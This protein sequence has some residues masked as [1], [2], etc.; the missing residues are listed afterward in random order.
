MPLRFERHGNEVN[1]V[2]QRKTP[3]VYSL[4]GLLASLILSL[5]GCSPP[6]GAVANPP[7]GGAT[8]DPV[9][10]TVFAAASLTDAFTE[11]GGQFEAANPEID[12][13]FNFA[14]SQQ[15]AQQL[16]QGAPADVFASANQRQMAV[17]ITSGRIAP[18]APQTFAQN[19][20]VVIFPKD[21]PVGISRLQDLAR[22][23]LNLVLAGKAVPAGGYALDFLAK[24]DQDAD[25][26]PNFKD[27]TLQNV[28]SYEQ[29]VRAVLV[30]VSLGEADAGI[31]Y[32]S[33]I[34]GSNA[35]NVGYVDIPDRL[36]IIASYPL[37]PIGDSPNLRPAQAFINFVLSSPGQEILANHGFL[38]FKSQ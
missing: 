2:T 14:G 15:L 31:V 13:V 37:A 20:L 1:D 30:K 16:S 25:F 29:N 5:T 4:Y 6:V 7:G 11:I 22:P 3:M 9:T 28:V 34:N 35:R 33:D 23:G 32:L 27:K 24:A 36:N 18:D 21:N 38:P 19:R 26:G 17:V 10:L 12:L 8:P